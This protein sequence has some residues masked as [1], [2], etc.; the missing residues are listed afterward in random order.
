[1]DTTQNVQDKTPTLEDKTPKGKEPS[2]ASKEPSPKEPPTTYTKEDIERAVQLARMQDGRER[3]ALET[4]RDDLKVQVQTKDTE[5]ANITEAKKKL[6]E[7]IDDLSSDDPDKVNFVKKLK[8]LTVQEQSLT[9]RLRKL[10]TDEQAYGE[11][12]KKAE[13]LETEVLILEIVE[14]YE[15]ADAE[16][17][18]A[19]CSTLNATSEEQIRKVAETLWTKKPEPTT[20]PIATLTGTTEGGRPDYSGLSATKKIELGLKTQSQ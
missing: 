13:S 8:D 5:L 11:R 6:E 20:P 3:K 18:S 12:I 16:K 4:E 2:P 9:A 14:D 19:I 17:L 10:D 15:S 1:M 7:Q